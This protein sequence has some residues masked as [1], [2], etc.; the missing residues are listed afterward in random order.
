MTVYTTTFEMIGEGRDLADRYEQ[1]KRD[2]AGE[3]W[4]FVK[5][6]GGAGYCPSSWNGALQSVLFDGELPEGWR[7]IGSVKGM[8]NA[9]PRA[10]TKAGKAWLAKIE[11]LPAKPLPTSL[12]VELGYAR[13]SFAIDGSAI[14]F[15][16]EIRVEHPETR[17]F[18]RL[19]LQ[20]GDGFEPDLQRLKPVAE[21]ELMKAVEDHNAEAKRLREGGLA[22]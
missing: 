10:S 22:A 16:T 20:A 13:D 9:V 8:T 5:E 1:Q 12:A 7:R 14:Y 2:A 19:P 11:A 3:Q 17:H 18:L 15:P 21:S 6:V 4:A